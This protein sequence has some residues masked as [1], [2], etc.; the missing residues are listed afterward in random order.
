MRY[1]QVVALTV[2]AFIISSCA[3]K[4]APVDTSADVTALKAMQDRELAGVASGNVDSALTVFTSDAI[5]M[6]PGE[7]A[8]VGDAA[9]RKWFTDFFNSAVVTGKY[10]EA[11]VTVQGDVGIVRYVG[12]LTITPKTADAKPMTQKLKGIHVY[13]RQ[14]D[15]NWKIAQDVWNADTPPAPAPAAQKK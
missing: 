6:A 7:P 12:E 1:V 13:K 9:I 5:V 2:V 10:S 14:T 8:L 11:D 3:A 4:P 15:G